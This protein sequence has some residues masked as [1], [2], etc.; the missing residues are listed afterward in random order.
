VENGFMDILIVENEP[1]TISDIKST[2]E[3]L[4][5]EV[6]AVAST[7][8][9]AIAKTENLNPDL[10]IINIQLKG[11]ISGVETAKHIAERYDIPIIFLT[12]FIKNCL[13]KSLQLPE[14]AIVLSMPVK[15]EHLE[16][17]ISRAFSGQG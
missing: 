10:I 1:T 4:G 16:Y 7:G 11:A 6:V 5:H 2:L 14:D 15:Q 17:C 12:V 8:Q 3:N 9:E 13:N